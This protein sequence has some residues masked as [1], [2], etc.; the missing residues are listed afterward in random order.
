LT[1]P[2]ARYVRSLPDVCGV[3]LLAHEQY[4]GYLRG[5]S[6]YEQVLDLDR[7][8]LHSMFTETKSFSLPDHDPL[9]D[10][11]G[12]YGL[13]VTLLSDKEGWFE[14]NL[15][16]TA[17][18]AHPCEVVTIPVRPPGDYEGHVTTFYLET[19]REQMFSETPAC[20]PEDDTLKWL[21]PK[22]SDV[23]AGEN[24]L[25]AAGVNP[26]R[27]V[28]IHP[29]SG[30]LGKCWPL[31]R[32][33]RLSRRLSSAGW[34][35]AMVAGPA[36]ME[37]FEDQIER[38]HT[39]L[40][41]IKDLESADLLA[42]LLCCIGYVGNDS[43]PSHLA[44]ALGVPGVAIFGPSRVAHWRPLGRSVQVCR[45]S[46]PLDATAEEPLTV[47][48]PEVEDVADVVSRTIRNGKKP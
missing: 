39:Q 11:F 26:Q 6:V 23:L 48:W 41:V 18:V 27:C 3:D 46:T 21:K 7:M 47:V 9:I 24:L 15:V 17:N 22:P 31:E 42:L 32:F 13:I 14:S 5:R 36:E 30:G 10:I 34:D 40:P 2:L 16:Y 44:G 43:G 28:L 38:L 1:L 19:F 35:V 33:E 29:G 20:P 25:T 12:H 8:E 4:G 45:A 37:R